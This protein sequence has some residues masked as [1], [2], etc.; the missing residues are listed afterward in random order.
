MIHLAGRAIMEPEEAVAF[1]AF[2]PRLEACQAR[3][4]EFLALS[5]ILRRRGEILT[6]PH[7]RKP[8][9][10]EKKSW[11]LPDGHP[12]LALVPDIEKELMFEPPTEQTQPSLE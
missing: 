6:P 8:V 7:R 9:L 5:E 4:D 12:A 3:C 2:R 10:D 11:R 1:D